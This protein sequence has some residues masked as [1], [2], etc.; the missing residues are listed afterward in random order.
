[1]SLWKFI[2]VVW[3]FSL[4]L[5]EDP[6]PTQRV[7]PLNFN[8][9]RSELPEPV[10]ATSTDV[11]SLAIESTAEF[12]KS[13]YIQECITITQNHEACQ[14]QGEG[15]FDVIK[16]STSL[17]DTAHDRSLILYAEKTEL[18]PLR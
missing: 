4:L 17:S 10:S 16:T 1:M 6:R 7:Q 3:I 11:T 2:F 15:I 12:S 18:Q 5:Q 13:S 9:Y 14:E 8:E